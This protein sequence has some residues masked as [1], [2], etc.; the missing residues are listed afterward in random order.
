MYR[1]R[2]FLGW[3][4]AGFNSAT[5]MLSVSCL[6]STKVFHLKFFCEKPVEAHPGGLNPPPLTLRLPPLLAFVG[7]GHVFFTPLYMPR[8]ACSMGR[9]S[10]LVDCLTTWFNSPSAFVISID[11]LE[12][13]TLI[14]DCDISAPKPKV[15]GLWRCRFDLLGKLSDSAPLLVLFWS[16]Y[17]KHGDLFLWG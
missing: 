5:V 6:G 11:A 2:P 9:R 7:R 10:S 14:F 4:C 17:C 16:V 13:P 12:V 1:Y 8:I 15:F 3:F